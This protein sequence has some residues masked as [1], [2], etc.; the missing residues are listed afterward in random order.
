M[1]LASRADLLI[2]PEPDPRT[3]ILLRIVAMLV[4][5]VRRTV[6]SGTGSGSGS[7]TK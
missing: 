4:Q 5:M 1:R 3:P 7:G 2:V 6:E